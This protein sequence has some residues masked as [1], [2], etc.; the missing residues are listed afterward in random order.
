[1]TAPMSIG[2]VSRGVTSRAALLALIVGHVAGMID[3]AALPIWVNT[4]IEGYGYRPALA[5]LM[6]TLFLLGVVLAS[7]VTSRNFGRLPRRL[8]TPAGYAVA[9]LALLAIS[10][11]DRAAAHLA[12]HLAGGL[13]TGCALSLVHGTLG[14]GAN[15]HRAFACAGVGFGVFSMLFLG[16]VPQLV[17]TFGPAAFF[18]VAA[19]IMGLAALVTALWMPAETLHESLLRAPARGPFPRQVRLAIAGIMGMA[20]VQGMVF[21]F[22]VQAGLAHGFGRGRV[23]AVLIALGIVNLVPPIL[24]AL[25]QK[26]LRA[27]TVAPLGPLLQGGFALAIMGAPGF[28]V[29]AVPAVFFAA[30][31]IFTHTFVFGF[32]AEQDPSGRA[33]ALTPAMLM[34]GSAA[35]PFLGGAMV[36]AWGLAAIGGLGLVVGLLCATLFWL[37]RRDAAGQA[38][39]HPAL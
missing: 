10:M 24:A 22:L 7:L 9:G 14:R 8:L 23:E 29:F 15:P 5:G 3:L 34:T 26:R 6:P 36:E 13:A 12:L 25:L 31:L 18:R 11:T 28:A 16:A 35:A 21:S 1:M 2:P 32:L 27:M 33:V 4:L 30:V 38:L 39:V 17:L 19:G 37:A 20:L